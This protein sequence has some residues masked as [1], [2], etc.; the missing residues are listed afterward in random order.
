MVD[1]DQ[2][3]RRLETDDLGRLL[4]HSEGDRCR[5][6]NRLVR[7]LRWRVHRH[8]QSCWLGVEGDGMKVFAVSFIVS[9]MIAL[10]IVT[11]VVLLVAALLSIAGKRK[12][13]IAA[14]DEAIANYHLATEWRSKP[15]GF[16]GTGD[17]CELCG[18][19]GLAFWHLE[20]SDEV[21]NNHATASQPQPNK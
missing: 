21:A 20:W 5:W 11:I 15:H 17:R 7:Y 4:Q 18:V 3:P 1:Y 19:R 6:P 12:R 14:S 16:K 8:I 10:W 9:L 2:L 13:L